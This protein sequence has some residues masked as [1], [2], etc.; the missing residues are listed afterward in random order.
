MA[1]FQLPVWVEYVKALGAPIVALMAA[2]IAGGIAY[3]Q[4][5]TARNKLKLDLFEKRLQVY[6]AAAVVVELINNPYAPDRDHLE[7]WISKFGSARWLFGREVELY[8]NSLQENAN[9]AYATK[10]HLQ[11]VDSFVDGDHEWASRVAKSKHDTA[12]EMRKLDFVFRDYLQL[13]H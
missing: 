4:W 9:F 1:D 2:C 10:L 6:N 3:Q 13:H 7:E 11:K 5:K 8:L 12:Q